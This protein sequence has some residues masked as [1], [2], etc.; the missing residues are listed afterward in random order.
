[1]L[2]GTRLCHCRQQAILQK[3]QKLRPPKGRSEMWTQII[4]VRGEPCCNCPIPTSPT[5]ADLGFVEVGF[6]ELKG[7]LEQSLRCSCT[8][9][10]FSFFF[11]RRK[12][13][14]ICFFQSIRCHS[15]SFSMQPFNCP[16]KADP[17]YNIW[18][19]FW[20]LGPQKSDLQHFEG[21]L[22]AL[23]SVFLETIPVLSYAW[24]FTIIKIN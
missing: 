4:L 24:V 10:K 7:W 3:G 15:G 12:W 14:A 18:G 1:M 17:S 11:Q 20:N 13:K 2:I 5:E 19:G 23:H 6:R 8:H 16:R 21:W 9:A 22:L